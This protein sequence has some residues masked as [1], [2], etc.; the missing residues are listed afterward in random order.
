MHKQYNPSF[1]ANGFERKVYK[2]VTVFS[3]YSKKLAEVM[4]MEKR[5]FVLVQNGRDTQHVYTGRSPRQAALKAAS[6]GLKKIE[7]RE[8]GTKK[9]HIYVGSRE[10]VSAPE[11]APE[12]MSA[13]VWKP[14]VKKLGIRKLEEKK[15]KTAKKKKK[16]VRRKKKTTKRRTTKKKKTTKKKTTKRKATKRKTTKRR[17]R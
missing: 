6:R 3:T 12:W 1:W 8:R 17:R 11:N 14:R 7:L 9:I 13:K 2:G 16:V 10:K 15:K 5:Y 4:W